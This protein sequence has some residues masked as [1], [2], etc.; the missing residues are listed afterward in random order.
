MVSNIILRSM[1]KIAIKYENIVLHSGIFALRFWKCN[2]S[3]SRSWGCSPRPRR[4]PPGVFYRLEPMENRWIFL[5]FNFE[6]AGTYI[7][8][9][10]NTILRFVINGLFYGKR[11][12]V[13]WKTTA[14]FMR[15]N[16]SFCGKRR[17]VL[18]N[19][20]GEDDTEKFKL[21]NEKLNCEKPYNAPSR[22]RT[23]AFT[24]VFTFLLSQVSQ[25][26]LK[27]IVW[28]CVTSDCR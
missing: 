25:D 23:R 13:L 6:S 2:R 11:R 26:Y 7:L 27:S 22:V 20:M 5:H 14:R 24:G 8:I 15:N 10:Y 28:Q 4:P 12:L 3:R 18:G 21:K 9:S 16:G 1:A 17:L 19:A